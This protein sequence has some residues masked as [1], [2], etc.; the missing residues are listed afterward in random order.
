VSPGSACRSNRKRR[1]AL[2]RF[3]VEV[4]SESVT[5]SSQCREELRDLF[6]IKDA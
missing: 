2:R 5:D 1:T 4:V 6:G 3:L